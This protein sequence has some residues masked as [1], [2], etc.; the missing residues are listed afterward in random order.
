MGWQFDIEST[1]RL[2]RSMT[3]MVLGCVL[4][5]IIMTGGTLL[6]TRFLL[7]WFVGQ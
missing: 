1:D 4:L 5:G 6:V 2:K 7:S 3:T